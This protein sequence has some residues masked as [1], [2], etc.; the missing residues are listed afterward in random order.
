[1]KMNP[2]DKG[3]AI[4]LVV[5]ICV[6]LALVLIRLM[7]KSEDPQGPPETGGA[8]ASQMPTTQQVADGKAVSANAP[9]AAPNLN[10]VFVMSGNEGAASANPFRRMVAP[11]R[12]T[13]AGGAP[14]ANNGIEVPTQAH[15]DRQISFGPGGIEPV[16]VGN[17][18][19]APTVNNSLGLI[20][21]GIIAPISANDPPMAFIRIGEETKGFRAGATVAPGVSIIGITD[22]FV[23]FR[24]GSTTAK[25]MVG[26]EI[27]PE[28]PE[29]PIANQ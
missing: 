25:I 2:A 20:L 7:P 3:K 15:P 16:K 9:A 1:M 22:S 26:R 6:V 27:K 14:P 4:A 23:I 12:T 5:A 21:K 18:G 19:V 24:I 13:V 8:Q 17:P 10:D 29:A 28:A 11:P